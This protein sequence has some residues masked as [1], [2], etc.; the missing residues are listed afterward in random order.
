ML[1]GT[2]LRLLLKLRLGSNIFG[3]EGREERDD[4]YQEEL[5]ME[6]HSQVSRHL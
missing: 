6:V 5:G 4:I 1:L 2:R 3:N